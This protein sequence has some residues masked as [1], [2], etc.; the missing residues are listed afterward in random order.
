V[1]FSDASGLHDG[2][3]V[4]IAGV[5]VGRVESL[6]LVGTHAEVAISVRSEQPVFTNTRALIRYQNLV[7]QRYLSLVAGDGAA[8]PLPD[9]GRI[10]LDRTEPSFDLSALLNGFAPLFT[11]LKPADVNRLADN[12]VQVLQGSGPEID[13][14]LEQTITLTNA[15]ADRDKVIGAVIDNL[16]QVLDQIAGKGQQTDELLAQG[17]RLVDGLN[18]RT[19]PIFGSLE[20]VRAFTG[21]AQELLADIRPDVRRDVGSASDASAVFAGEKGALG[22]TLAGFPAFLSGLTRVTSYGSWANLYACGVRL[23]VPGVPAQIGTFPGD[24]HTEVCR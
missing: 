5:R 10:P 3:N 4:R 12:I 18:Q 8:R 7:G 2:D 19:Q 16:N 1:E 24:T 21:N 22:D 9:G 17:R 20:R 6:R 11:T 15:I 14:L 23:D 13:P